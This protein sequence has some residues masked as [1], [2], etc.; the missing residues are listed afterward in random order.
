MQDSMVMVAVQLNQK[1]KMYYRLD[2]FD[3]IQSLFEFITLEEMDRITENKTILIQDSIGSELDVF[4]SQ[5]FEE[6]DFEILKINFH[7]IQIKKSDNKDLIKSTLME[8]FSQFIEY[9]AKQKSEKEEKPPSQTAT[10]K[11]PSSENK[12]I[13]KDSGNTKSTTIDP[14]NE[15][16]KINPYLIIMET[17]N[18]SQFN[19]YNLIWDM[20]SIFKEEI[21]KRKETIRDLSPIF[22]F[23]FDESSCIPRELIEEALIL[24]RIPYPNRIQR[25]EIIDM[26]LKKIKVHTIDISK[27]AD[28]T[29]SWNVK[30]IEKLINAAYIRWKSINHKEIKNRTSQSNKEALNNLNPEKIKIK[31][32]LTEDTKP[33]EQGS[34]QI[35]KNKKENNAEIQKDLQSPKDSSTIEVNNQPN[36]IL[37]IEYLIPFT[38]E[39]FE[40]IIKKKEITPLHE[41]LNINLISTGQVYNNINSKITSFTAPKIQ[42]NK[43]Q[44]NINEGKVAK[45][46]FPDMTLIRGSN[47]NELNSFTTNQ[48][49]QFA[50]SNN[51]ED[52]IKV[53]EKLDQGKTLDEFD[54]KL[55]AD[56]SFILRD[57]PKTALS[58]LTNAKNRVDK[59]K[60]IIK[61]DEIK[62]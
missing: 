5:L 40:E 9:I 2:V 7:D 15:K 33:V 58:K 56:Y 21:L 44:D 38:I 47:I 37:K 10:V 22:L 1:K 11:E 48:L 52:L 53:I 43:E 25:L 30:D 12:I 20:Y 49:Y 3:E 39:I 55:L 27:L 19:T 14:S 42:S 61:T 29:E 41:F 8:E 31:E 36:P 59:L 13:D 4:L 54:R 60:N 32:G 23:I 6:L 35:N 62:E 45:Q 16:S 18:L 46:D 57:K 17:T 28:L 34:E 24:I 51:F 50:A 26:Y